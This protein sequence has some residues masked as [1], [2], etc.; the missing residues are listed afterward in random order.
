MAG[1]TRPSA[2]GAVE[3]R[4][5]AAQ[6]ARPDPSMARREAKRGW[7]LVVMPSLQSMAGIG[8]FRPPPLACLSR[9]CLQIGTTAADPTVRC[10]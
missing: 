9:C 1:W 6:V 8:E 2:A 5:S 10:R 3:G 7:S 4:Q